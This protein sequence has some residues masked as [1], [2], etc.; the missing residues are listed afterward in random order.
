MP[1][2]GPGLN[3][4][5]LMSPRNGSEDGKL[6]AIHCEAGS[7]R[8]RETHRLHGG[9]PAMALSTSGAA[10]VEA[11]RARMESVSNT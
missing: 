10:V 4:H 1:F 6:A 7:L 11:G 8:F 9:S 3:L 5:P 2:L